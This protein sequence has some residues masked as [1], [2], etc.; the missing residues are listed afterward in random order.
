MV[1]LPVAAL[2]MIFLISLLMISGKLFHNLAAVEDNII[3]K[4]KLHFVLL[5]SCKASSEHLGGGGS[6]GHITKECVVSHSSK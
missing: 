2:S 1:C 6:G 3:D 5:I 4:S